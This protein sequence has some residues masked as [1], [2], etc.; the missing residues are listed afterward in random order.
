MAMELLEGQS[1]DQR[2]GSGPLPL[3]RRLD[4]GIQLADALDAAHSKNIIHRDSK[5]ANI[6]LTQRGQVKILDFGLA[7]LARP[8]MGD[9]YHRPQ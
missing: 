7:K 5:P 3:D 9:G 1:L 6:F 4:V 2:L 8:D